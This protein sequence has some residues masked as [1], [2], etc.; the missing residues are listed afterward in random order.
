[1]DWRLAMRGS[2]SSPNNDDIGFAVSFVVVLT[3]A[4]NLK[5]NRVSLSKR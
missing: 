5:L 4:S 2:P 1:M 3:D